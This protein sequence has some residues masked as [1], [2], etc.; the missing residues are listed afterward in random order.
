ME[1]TVFGV[2]KK[3]EK[4]NP[5]PKLKKFNMKIR[6]TDPKKLVSVYDFKFFL[7]IGLCLGMGILFGG[8]LI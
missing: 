2:R 5:K 8:Y 7:K 3:I 6:V 1:S 4:P